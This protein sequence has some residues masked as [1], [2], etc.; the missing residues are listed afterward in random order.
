MSLNSTVTILLLVCL[1]GQGRGYSSFEQI[2]D[3]HSWPFDTNGRHDRVVARFS[4]RKQG[5]ETL[6]G[7]SFTSAK[8]RLGQDDVAIAMYVHPSATKSNFGTLEV[9]TNGQYSDEEQ[10]WAAGYVEG[11]VT[12][13]EI[14]QQYENLHAY[15]ESTMGADLEQPMEWIHE[16]DEWLRGVCRDNRRKER[17]DR[18]WMA[19]CL[20]LQQFDGVVQGYQAL[21]SEKPGLVPE[22]QYHDFL[23]LESNADL[24]DVIDALDPS[25]RP[26]WN[27]S[28]SGSQRKTPAQLLNELALE[29]SKC[30]ALI[31]FSSD[32]SELYMGHSTWD[33]YTAML[34]IYKHYIFDLSFTPA[35]AHM[36]FSSYPGEIFSDDDFYLLSSRM[37]LLQ[38]TNKIFNGK[39]FDKVLENTHVVLSWQ[40]VRAANLLAESGKE[41]AHLFAR[42]NSGTYNNQYMVIDLNSFDQGT[43]SPG[44]LTVVEQIPGLVLHDDATDI[45]TMAGY[46]PS[47]NIPYFK[48]IY[49]ASGYPDFSD[50]AIKEDSEYYDTLVWLSYTSAPRA[51]IFRRDHAAVDSVEGMQALMRRNNFKNDPLTKGNPVMAV[52]GRGDLSLEAPE[53][54]G[55]YDTKVTSS[56]MA[57]EFAAY[58]VNG[59]TTDGGLPPFSWSPDDPQLHQGHPEIFD[60]SFELMQPEN[61]EVREE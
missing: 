60:F 26:S 37:V 10:M 18:F 41:W 52:C 59:P 11:Y 32:L 44:L 24:Y 38:T 40:R 53:T 7:G 34:R 9:V 20:V 27:V 31:T 14:A 58:A 15:F 56:K 57:A 25:Q 23:F 3:R 33:S 48:E 6:L 36:S 28:N 35:G 50:P 4:S 54:R 29:Q 45:L 19:V 21:Y 42:E 49:E 43:I 55:C 12:A 30:S 16:Q 1:C 51:N 17:D 2:K 22:L 39:L 13:Q 61:I 46:W 5:V 47:Y 8:T